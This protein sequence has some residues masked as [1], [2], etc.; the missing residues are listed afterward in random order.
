VL[1][2]RSM[3]RRPLLVGIALAVLGAWTTTAT[4][5]EADTAPLP[6]PYAPPE[7]VA[8]PP[9]PPPQAAD[10]EA[11]AAVRAERASAREEKRRVRR[12]RIEALGPDRERLTEIYAISGIGTPVGA[13]GVEIVRRVGSAAEI[14]AGIGVGLTALGKQNPLQWAIMPRLR[15]G[16]QL[17]AFTAGI[18]ISGGQSGEYPLFAVADDADTGSIQSAYI[19]WAN[20]E[21]GGEHIAHG[22]YSFRYFA[23]WAKG[24]PT[25]PTASTNRILLS[26]P[27]AGVGFGYSF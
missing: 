15:A 21:L 16:A 9:T 8:A 4:A 24:W 25:S 11:P 20:F 17:N 12:E 27:Y 6:A 1:I 2:V 14:A 3:R 5:A 10:R 19:V 18:G 22:G 23:G 26:Y 7:P 13:S